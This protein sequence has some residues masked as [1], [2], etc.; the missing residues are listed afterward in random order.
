MRRF[1]PGWVRTAAIC[2]V[3]AATPGLVFAQA[4]AGPLP[5]KPAVPPAPQRQLP[6][7]QV[8]VV[9]RVVSAPAVVRD[10]KGD[11]VLDLQQKDFK[12]FD[13]GVAQAVE[14]FDIGGDPVSAV[15]VVET[16]QRIQPMLPTIQKAGIVFT[17]AVL[18][19]DGEGAVISYADEVTTLAPFSSNYD[20]MEKTI[21]RLPEGGPDDKLYDAMSAAVNLLHD[22]P[23]DR[24]R[25]MVV[26]GEAVDHGSSA[27]LGE[28]LRESQLANITIY[29]VGISTT[30]AKMREPGTVVAPSPTPPGIYPDAPMP[31]TPQTPTTEMQRE[32]YGDLGGLVRWA[33]MNAVGTVKSNSLELAAAATGGAHVG[34]YHDASIEKGLDRIAGEV[35]AQYTLS[36]HPNGVSGQGYH[37]I[38]IEVDRKGLKVF[39]KPGY[40]LPPAAGTSE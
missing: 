13:N 38:K 16:S 24:R 39:T 14:H 18:G 21:A 4:G 36:Y 23:A 32:G 31:G 34:T 22:Q 8:R 30:G 33:V 37:E 3:A 5:A 19:E 12:I 15:L 9:T 7:A 26:I 20:A 35:H 25:V 40:Y 17:D 28:V 10:G 2:L 1:W 11:M 6:P 29:S 27:K